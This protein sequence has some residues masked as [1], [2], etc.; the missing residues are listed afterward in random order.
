MQKQRCVIIGSSPD[1]DI[2]IIAKNLRGH[3]FIAC[4]DGG[5]VYAKK[6]GLKPDLIAG[7]FDSSER[8]KN[9]AGRIVTLPRAKDDTDT[10]YLVRECVKMGFQEFL[11][12]GCTGGRLD[13]TV[14]NFCILHYLSENGKSAE[15]IDS[16]N[17]IFTLSEGFQTVD[18]LNGHGFSIFPF[19]C[20]KCILT[21]RGFEYEI[22]NST[23]SSDF[24]IGVSNILRS[25]HSV[26]EIKCGSA[27][28]IITVN[29]VKE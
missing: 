18:N 1:T 11:L 25:D 28:V 6:L 13:H 14:A 5:Y 26:I 20:S 4:A 24:P 7:D 12:F 23:I 3:D 29:K 2:D 22:E 16:E 9:I 21:L 27:I 10:M 19:G 17:I 15:M 8:P